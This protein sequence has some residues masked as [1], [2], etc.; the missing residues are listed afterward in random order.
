M[1]RPLGI[2]GV[3]RLRSK[4]VAEVSSLG[5]HSCRSV[6][7]TFQSSAVRP[8]IALSLRHSRALEREFLRNNAAAGRHAD[9]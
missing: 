5:R 6:A 3:L 9:D 4:L 1:K 8:A 7:T 2:V